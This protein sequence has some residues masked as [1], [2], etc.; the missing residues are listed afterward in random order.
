MARNEPRVIMPSRLNFFP[1]LFR[2]IRSPLFLAVAGLWLLLLAAEALSPCLFLHD[3]NATWFIGSYVHDFRVLTETGRLAEVNYYQHAGEPFIQQGQSAVLYPPVYLGVALAKAFCGELRWSLEWIAALHL[4]IGLFGFYFWLRQGGI[5]PGHAALG[6]LAWVLNPFVLLVGD[7]WIFMTYIAAWLPWFF[8]ALDRLLARTSLRNALFLG[9]I[10][11]LLFLQGYVQMF[12][13]SILFLAIYALIQFIA[14][15]ETRNLSVLYYLI[16][17]VLLFEI[18]TL[19]LLLPLYYAVGISAVRANPLPVGAALYYSIAPQTFFLPQVCLFRPNLV[20]GLSTAILYCPALLFIPAMF[21][22]LFYV[23]G[24]V[25]LRLISLGILALLALFFSTEGHALLTALPLFDRFRWPFKVFLFADFFLIASFAWTTA[26]WTE[27][28][29]PFARWGNLAATVCLTVV[30]LANLG[31]SFAFHDD[32]ILTGTILP[33]SYNPVL[34]GMDGR[35]GRVVTFG[36]HILPEF[37]SYRFLSHAYAT[38]YGFPSLGGYNPLVGLKQL[39]YAYYLDYPNVCMGTLTRDFQK[40]FEE[41]SVRYWIVDPQSSRFAEA[42][43]L[44]GLRLMEATTDRVVYE[45]TLAAPLVY[46]DAAPTV[47]CAMNYSGNSMLIPLAGV[48]SPVEVSV[49]PTDGWWYRIDHGPWLRADYQDYRLKIDFKT[50]NRLLEVS[51]FD[52][53]FLAGLHWS[54]Y[55]V[56]FLPLFLA[57]NRMFLRK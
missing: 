19:P 25:R 38:Y 21:L 53:H 48:I 35:L 2:V 10:A 33:A 41:R 32:N 30:M 36:D 44:P 16:V 20:F 24:A 43:K 6:G 28:R 9:L 29:L 8:W 56:V 46:S 39:E 40:C 52:P 27:S 47:P 17:S 1:R 49:A 34:P 31:I 51:Y 50:S 42:K 7:S 15:P 4:T 5:A 54:G 26:S 13:Y 22:R 3:D 23:N 45:D 18:L 37:M 12:A 11:G 55:L 57:G 14:R